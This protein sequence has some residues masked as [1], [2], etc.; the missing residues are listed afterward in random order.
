MLNFI[1]TIKLLN[2]D[3][4][5]GFNILSVALIDDFVIFTFFIVFYLLYFFFSL[6]LLSI[7]FVKKKNCDLNIY[8]YFEKKKKQFSI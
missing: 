3:Q 5:I 1:I 7:V 4:F 6:F 2:S 8:I